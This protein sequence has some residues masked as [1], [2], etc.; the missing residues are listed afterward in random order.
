MIVKVILICVLIVL[1]FL[2]CAIIVNRILHKKVLEV[3][4]AGQELYNIRNKYKEKEKELEVIDNNIQF[5]R[6]TITDLQNKISKKQTECQVQEQVCKGIEAQ[7]ESTNHELDSLNSIFAKN[8][9]Q[10]FDAEEQN[11]QILD[12][13]EEKFQNDLECLIQN[14]ENKS[15]EYEKQL[16]DLREKRDAAIQTAIDEYEASNIKAFYMLQL[17]DNDIEDIRFLNQLKDK[18][19]N[20]EILG[21]LIYKTYIEKAY[22]DLIGRVLNKEDF[23]GIYKITNELNQ[24]C[25]VG[26][27]A[28]IKK[29]WQQHIKRAVGAEPLVNNKLYPAMQQYGVE[30]FSFEVIDR[31]SKDK[32]NERE[33]YWQDFYSAKKFGY[34]IK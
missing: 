22:T 31:C 34:S 3:R 29:R 5:G 12:S 19:H 21:K 28:S 14:Y 23:S 2:I 9:Q 10:L 1:T 32:L 6:D 13:I 17:T 7:I 18:L 30:N 25:Y 11:Q 33:Q 16:E 15:E 4:E 8:K 27:A 24:M 20:T 26:Q